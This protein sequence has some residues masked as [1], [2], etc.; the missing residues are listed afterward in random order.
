MTSDSERNDLSGSGDDPGSPKHSKRAGEP[1]PGL[2]PAPYASSSPG[3]D[4]VQRSGREERVLEAVGEGATGDGV[5]GAQAATEDGSLP[6]TRRDGERS[7]DHDDLV[8]QPGQPNMGPPQTAP[9]PRSQRT[10]T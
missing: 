1:D 4:A 8:D 5:E 6:E 2:D 7:G 3:P 10:D 9:P